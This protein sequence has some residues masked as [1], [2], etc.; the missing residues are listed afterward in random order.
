MNL[1]KDSQRLTI[2]GRTGSGKTQAALWHLSLRSWDVRPWVIYDYKGDDLIA[3]IP[4]TKN[5]ALTEPPPTKPG[6]Y[7]VRPH[8]DDSET[9]Q[10]Q[11]WK[12]WEQ[13]GIGIYV[14]EGY[15]ICSPQQ[16][17]PPFRSILTQGRSK[18]IPVII[19]SQRPVWLD[20]FVFSET[21]F[22][23]VFALNAAKD[24]QTIMSYVPADLDEKLP[25]YHSYYYDVGA[26]DLKVMKPVPPI[27]QIVGTFRRRQEEIERKAFDAKQKSRRVFI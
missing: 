23:Q 9:V 22:Y 15:M 16:P 26:N 17:N 5:L 27:E 1:P 14:D 20:R 25:D 18:R 7:I 6:I 21:D 4:D 19:L 24:R 3:Q 12:I 2:I 10:A 8:P 13:E 11:L